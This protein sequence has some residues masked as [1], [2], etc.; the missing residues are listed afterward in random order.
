MSSNG[1][2][3]PE[4][5]VNYTDGFA[6]SKGKMEE[7]FRAGGILEKAP[8]KTPAITAKDG[9]VLKREDIDLIMHEFEIPRAHAERALAEHGGNIDK[10]LR[11]LVAPPS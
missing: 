10:T 6:Y 11:A 2:P 3:E 4:V 1:R 5:I 8:T 9:G 7:A